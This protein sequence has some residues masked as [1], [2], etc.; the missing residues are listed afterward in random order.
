MFFLLHGDTPPPY[1]RGG[2]GGNSNHLF[3]DRPRLLV[4]F[5]GHAW[6]DEYYIGLTSRVPHF[7]VGR[8]SMLGMSE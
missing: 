2:N 1:H 4:G 5:F 7:R 8:R 3:E 6:V